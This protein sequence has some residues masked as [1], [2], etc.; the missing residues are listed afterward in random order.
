LEASVVQCKRTS[1]CELK[2]ESPATLTLL[3]KQI[4]YCYLLKDAIEQIISRKAVLVKRIKLCETKKLYWLINRL[5]MVS[6]KDLSR[7]CRL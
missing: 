3:C 2:D 6:S 1:A 7:T 5:E 4:Q